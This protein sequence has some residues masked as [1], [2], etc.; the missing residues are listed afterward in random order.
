MHPRVYGIGNLEG[1]EVFQFVF[2]L[3]KSFTQH[4]SR[5]SSLVFSRMLTLI[6]NSLL[7]QR[8][9]I[10]EKSYLCGFQLTVE[11]VT[12]FY[13]S[14][15]WVSSSFQTVGLQLF[16]H[17][18]P[19]MVLKP[20]PNLSFFFECILLISIP[21]KLVRPGSFLGLQFWSASYGTQTESAL[22]ESEIWDQKLTSEIL[23]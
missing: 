2:S 1:R 17:F 8:S 16:V 11:E 10:T 18:T 21:L 5:C 22:S 20:F 14:M 12:P 23:M 7:L 15:R 13:T 9:M 4:L 19:D 3:Q 6:G